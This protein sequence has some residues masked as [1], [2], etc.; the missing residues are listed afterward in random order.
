M[1]SIDGTGKLNCR[2]VSTSPSRDSEVGWRFRFASH[3][4]KFVE[5]REAGNDTTCAFHGVDSDDLSAIWKILRQNC[6]EP[7]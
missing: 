1:F 5:T 4:P 2:V 3:F 7:Q 6:F